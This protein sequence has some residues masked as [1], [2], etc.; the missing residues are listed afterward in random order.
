MKDRPIPSNWLEPRTLRCKRYTPPMV[1][2]VESDSENGLPHLVDL[3]SYSGNGACDCR[4]FVFRKEPDLRLGRRPSPITRCKH[5][6][7]AREA[8]LNECI[9]EIN[10]Q[11][12]QK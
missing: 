5:I 12:K 7:A 1:W 11:K 8:L 9:R 4:D 3:S 10:E 2:Q 6:K